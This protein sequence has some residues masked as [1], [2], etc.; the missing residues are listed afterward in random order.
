MPLVDRDPYLSHHVTGDRPGRFRVWWDGAGLILTDGRGYIDD[1]AI[2][3]FI[4][5]VDRALAEG[6]H[7]LSIFHDWSEVSGH[8]VSVGVRLTTKSLST[9]SRWSSVLVAVEHPIIAASI[10]S[11][12]FTFGRKVRRV[13]RLELYEAVRSKLVN[14]QLLRPSSVVL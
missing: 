13:P 9:M 10:V 14:H 1:K 7:M 2:G 6:D 3:S 12:S 8:A 4:H 5:V 11:A